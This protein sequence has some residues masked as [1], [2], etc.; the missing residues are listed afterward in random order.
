MKCYLL[1]LENL[2]YAMKWAC[3][4]TYS[5][6]DRVYV[7]YSDEL[8]NFYAAN[9][10]RL[11]KKCQNVH[12]IKI[13]SRS[14]NALDFNLSGVFGMLVQE[15]MQNNKRGIEI[16]IV[17]EDKGYK[18]LI[19]LARW[20]KLNF[21][22]NVKITFDNN[23]EDMDVIKKDMTLYSSND[24]S[25]MQKMGF[26]FYRSNKHL[27]FDY[28]LNGESGDVKDRVWR[29]LVGSC[30]VKS[31]IY[32][33]IQKFFNINEAKRLYDIIKDFLESTDMEEAK[34]LAI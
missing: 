34:S 4:Q 11:K 28:V 1:D 33:S 26:T 13:F 25:L 14:S 6:E 30:W 10:V 27:L 12:V 15:C 32:N 2:P 22:I 21:G 20:S 18:A 16:H 7:L 19:D 3:R 31:N 24:V 23:R 17:S 9:L 29:A 8:H 5:S